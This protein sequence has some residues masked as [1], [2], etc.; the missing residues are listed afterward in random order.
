MTR[1]KQIKGTE[2]RGFCAFDLFWTVFQM[3]VPE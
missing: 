1:E 2:S 3:I